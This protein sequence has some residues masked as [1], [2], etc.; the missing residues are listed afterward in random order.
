MMNDKNLALT[1]PAPTNRFQRVLIL[2]AAGIL[3]A[4]LLLV[5]YMRI[6]PHVEHY[7]SSISFHS[8]V[9][10]RAENTNDPARIFMVDDLLASH[11]LVGMSRADV[12]T[13][14]GMPP[15][16]P[17]FSSYQ[18]VYW[19]GPERSFIPIDSEWLGIKFD[20]DRVVEVKFLSD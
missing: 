3:F 2:T 10:K 1:R 18:Y 4:F 15:K 19:L 20:K 13:L 17:F 11:Q 12:D 16:T 6:V 14:L 9:W 5:A 7:F 8:Q